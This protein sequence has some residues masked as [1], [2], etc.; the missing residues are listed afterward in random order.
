[1]TLQDVFFT[2]AHDARALQP[3]YNC[4]TIVTFSMK[5]MTYVKHSK[6]GT[7][8]LVRFD[9]RERDMTD[10]QNFNLLTFREVGELQVEQATAAFRA[11]AKSRNLSPAEIEEAVWRFNMLAKVYNDTGR[12]PATVRYKWGQPLPAKDQRLTDIVDFVRGCG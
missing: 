10:K 12:D 11:E 9:E 4:V 6:A 8:L 3:A 1:M 2:R 5:S 7:A